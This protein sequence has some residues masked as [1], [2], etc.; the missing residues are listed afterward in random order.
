M[1][2]AIQK[3]QLD[4]EE[5]NLVILGIRRDVNIQTGER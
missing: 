2:K 3:L 5:S 4:I 1:E